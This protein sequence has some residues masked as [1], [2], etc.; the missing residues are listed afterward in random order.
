MISAFGTKM[1]TIPNSR[2]LGLF[3]ITDPAAYQF[4]LDQQKIVWNPNEVS[5][6]QDYVNFCKL[7]KDEQT[8][9]L[10]VLTI[11]QTLDGSVI[12]HFVLGLLQKAPTVEEQLPYIFQLCGEAVHSVSY[13]LQLKNLV[14]DDKERLLLL[15]E[16]DS[17]PWIKDYQDFVEKYT[18]EDVPE[19]IS[20][21]AQSALEGIGF[22][23]LFAIVFWY[24]T[25]HFSHDI[26]G[27]TTSNEYIA[28]EEG[29]HRNFA[30][31]RFL[32]LRAKY[33]GDIYPQVHQI[34]TEL[35]EIIK[36][37]AV[38]IL[39]VDLPGLTR[40]DLINYSLFV[41]DMLYVD[42]GYSK[43]FNLENSL[44][45]MNRIGGIQKTSGFE[46]SNTDYNRG[47]LYRDDDRE[48]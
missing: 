48:F 18:A 7:T 37:A 22:S 47:D 21:I 31:F 15:Q 14:P 20:L 42:L 28:A 2:R 23:G 38:V 34:L 10:K 26:P 43:V 33:E 13:S 30:V 16:A 35:M 32:R 19:I 46:R 4:Y 8:P 6:S 9:L 41:T 12:D 27:V 44:K 25:S 29:I 24:R 5:F 45:Y 3:P 1:N 11:F 39:P 40:Q 36:R 17:Q